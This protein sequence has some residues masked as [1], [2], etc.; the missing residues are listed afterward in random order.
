VSEA[1]LARQEASVFPFQLDPKIVSGFLTVSVPTIVDILD[2]DH[3]LQNA[4]SHE[5]KPIFKTRMAGRAV[6]LRQ[7]PASGP[8]AD[9][10]G[11]FFAAVDACSEG[12]VL[13]IDLGGD[14]RVSG[15]GDL[16]VTALHAKGAAGAVMDG[17]V[18]DIEP[19]IRMGFPVFAASVSPYGCI[20]KTTAVGH[21]IP[22]VC[23][24][25]PVEPGDVIVGDWDG[26]VVI[27]QAIA[28]EVLAK[29][30]ATEERER[31]MVERLREA[32]R[33]MKIADIFAEF[34]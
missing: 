27:P 31:T 33:T 32:A 4:M 18:R 9:C 26:V 21:N 16:V 13:V 2:Y 23:G 22:V 19:M 3:G 14:K 6:T 34:E 5:I 28:A 8:T 30:I 24:G 7:V 10:V 1:T 12:S 20:G 11:Q 25:V 29:A 17:A 15:T